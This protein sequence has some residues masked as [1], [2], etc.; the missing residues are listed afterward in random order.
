MSSEQT[1]FSRSLY[2]WA[3]LLPSTSKAVINFNDCTVQ[4]SV[5]KR[6]K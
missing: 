5:K 2:Y 3:W 4:K 1:R 6:E